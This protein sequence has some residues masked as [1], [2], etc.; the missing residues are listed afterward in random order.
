[1]AIP[2]LAS[3]IMGLD[4]IEP[5]MRMFLIVY[6]SPK[7]KFPVTEDP[8]LYEEPLLLNMAFV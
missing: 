3:M 5:S 7:L 8:D 1:M 4:L 6:L 2:E